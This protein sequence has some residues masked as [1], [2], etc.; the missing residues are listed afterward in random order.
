MVLGSAEEIMPEDLP[1][2]LLDEQDASDGAVTPYHQAV[3]NAKKKVVLR[4]LEQAGG[5]YTHAAKALGLHPNYLHRLVRNLHLR[6]DC[7]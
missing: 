7:A 6:A 5:N 2:A 4:A 3:R 1:E